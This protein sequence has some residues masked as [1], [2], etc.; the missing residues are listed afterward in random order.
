M[1]F[2][3]PLPL[4]T[5]ILRGMVEMSCSENSPC[6]PKNCYCPKGIILAQYLTSYS[7]LAQP[8]L[9]YRMEVGAVIR[10]PFECL[11]SIH[12]CVSISP[13]CPTL[14][15]LCSPR[16]QLVWKDKL[17]HYRNRLIRTFSYRIFALQQA[18]RKTFIPS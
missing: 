12:L 9:T 11:T 17:H 10:G 4:C 3:I 13:G 16:L 8:G 15:F 5:L 7:L 6:Y 14:L 1:F 18:L 2:P